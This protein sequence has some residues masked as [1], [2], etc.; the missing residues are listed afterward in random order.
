MPTKVDP[1]GKGLAHNPQSREFEPHCRCEDLVDRRSVSTSVS[2]HRAVSD[3][4][5]AKVILFMRAKNFKGNAMLLIAYSISSCLWTAVGVI[6]S[7]RN[8]E[9]KCVIPIVCCTAERLGLVK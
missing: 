6:H 5:K 3:I 1:V 4:E 7:T 9:R 2:A 8:K